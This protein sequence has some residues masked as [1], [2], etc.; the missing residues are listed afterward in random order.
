MD[1]HQPVLLKESI[2]FLSVQKG[3]WYIDCNLGGAGH[4]TKI[5]E[6]GGKV[7]GIDVDQDALNHVA[8]KF[9]LDIIEKDDMRFA[10]SD[11]LIIV[12][13]NFTKM[14]KLVNYFDLAGKID[15]ILFDLGVS[16]YQFDNTDRGFSFSKDAPL[17]MRMDQSL[18]VTAAD[19]INSLS[20]KELRNL[21]NEYGEDNNA[22]RIAREIIR[23]RQT[24]RITNTKELA[25]IISGQTKKLFGLHPATKTFQ[26]LRIAVNG[27]LT[28]L[29]HALPKTIEIVNP[30]GRVVVISFHSLE[31]RIVK[32]VFKKWEE[33]K[34][35]ENLT[36]KPQ[37]A[38]DEETEEN[39][40]SRSAKLRAIAKL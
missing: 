1:Y 10:V 6:L 13:S 17:D 33:Q 12:Q 34:I 27:E 2:D 5:L 29:E 40:R 36:D 35:A 15:G 38:T 4:T 37:M 16:S 24:K 11:N 25:D 39:P 3:S 21:I 28:D 22:F 19:L 32:N 30:K 31:D 23:A 7:L 8:Q 20:E 14:E 9:N 26:A 18:S